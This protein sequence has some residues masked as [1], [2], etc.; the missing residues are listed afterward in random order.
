MKKIIIIILFLAVFLG[1]CIKQ[2]EDTNGTDDYTIETFTDEDITAN[3]TSYIIVSSFTTTINNVT[4]VKI[5]KFSGIY[6]L[7][8]TRVPNSNLQYQIASTCTSGN[9]RIVIV[10]DNEILDDVQINT[11]K[12]IS[13]PNAN[14]TYQLR[15]V[16]ESA[17]IEMNYSIIIG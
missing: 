10:K 9:F 1:G 3:R 2:I 15:I 7:E 5:G 4:T 12:T 13:Y 11:S 8:K 6:E 14:G 17:K 16:G